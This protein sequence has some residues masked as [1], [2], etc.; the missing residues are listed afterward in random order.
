MLLPF[1]HC[2]GVKFE[3]KCRGD[4]GGRRRIVHCLQSAKVLLHGVT[5]ATQL[6]ST[7]GNNLVEICCVA[8]CTLHT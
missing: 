1:E 8:T 6:S 7:T 2:V 5:K 4:K 3:L